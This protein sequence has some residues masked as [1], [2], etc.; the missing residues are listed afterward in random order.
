MRRTSL[1]HR[2]IYGRSAQ[3]RSYETLVLD[4]VR[5]RL[6]RTVATKFEGQLRS[7]PFR[8]RHSN[9]RV[10]AFFP[11]EGTRMPAE[12]LFGNRQDDL[13]FATA[14]LSSASDGRVV[15]AKLISATGFFFSLEF[16]ESPAS[17]GIVDGGPIAI[18]NVNVSKELDEGH[19]DAEGEIPVES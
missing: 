3:L 17:K 13:V 12:F 18:K 16:D 4:S 5:Q 14:E 10:L 2:L 15:G 19:D 6:P 8:Q 9:D 1:V 7:L 11:D